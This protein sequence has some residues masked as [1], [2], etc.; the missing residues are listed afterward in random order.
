MV[1]K[2]FRV[3]E[4]RHFEFRAEFF[5]LFNRRNFANPSGALPNRLGE[6]QPGE[7]FTA[8]LAG[9]FG[10]VNDTISSVVGLGTPRQMQL[11][12]RFNF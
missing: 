5:N 2:R 8:D 11:S 7:P 3:D 12:L 9:D 1:Q 10:L 4:S 6:L